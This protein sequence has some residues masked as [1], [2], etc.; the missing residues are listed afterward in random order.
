VSGERRDEGED[1]VGDDVFEKEDG[2][3]TYPFVKLSP[4]RLFVY[5]SK[6]L[7]IGLK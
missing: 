1:E 4:N 7:V 5:H 3:G 6:S 2:I